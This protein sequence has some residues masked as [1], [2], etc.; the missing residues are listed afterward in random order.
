MKKC[1][2]FLGMK[3][4]WQFA[5]AIALAGGPRRTSESRPANRPVLRVVLEPGTLVSNGYS[6]YQVRLTVD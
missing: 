1:E 5:C 2:G 6:A 3:K 4:E